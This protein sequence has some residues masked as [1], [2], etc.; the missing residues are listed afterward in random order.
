MNIAGVDVV[1]TAKATFQGFREDDLQ[2]RS[3]AVA[4]NTL[5]SVVPLLIFLT[6]LSGFVARAVGTN[7]TMDE[8]TT[9]LFNHMGSD[10]ASALRDPIEKAINRS[11]GGLLSVG[12]VLALWGGKNVIATVM[13]ALNVAFDVEET[14]SWPKRNAVAIGLT[15]G[16]GLA[17]IVSSALFLAGAGFAAK[18]TGK[19]GFGDTWRTVWFYARWPVIAVILMVAVAAL[20]WAAPSIDAPFKWLTPGSVLTVLLWG[21]ASVGLGFYFANFAGYAGGTYGAL[22]GVLAFI[23]WLYVMSLILL[24]GAE[25]NAVLLAPVS[26]PARETTIG[27]EPEMRPVVAPPA[28]IVPRGT[29]TPA[30]PAPASGRTGRIAAT[31]AVSTVALSIKLFAKLRAV[32]KHA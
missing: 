16:F 29:S 21:A 5:F 27:Q 18:L 15:I 30:A 9:W 17:M 4:Y 13:S 3:A 10:S 24:I 20:Y 8:I 23:F 14:R 28:P 11:N 22:G 12:A 32:T 6:A 26:D 2:N 7:D 19:I 25:L 1:A 31:I